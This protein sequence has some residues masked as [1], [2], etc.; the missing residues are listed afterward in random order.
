MSE[1]KT[2][3]N[4]KKADKPL[5]K[6]DVLELKKSLLSVRKD[7]E[8]KRNELKGRVSY[9]RK[10]SDSQEI[11]EWVQDVQKLYTQKDYSYWKLIRTLNKHK[12]L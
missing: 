3:D 8:K 2:R 11:P 9:M 5:S 7:L 1:M 6:K 4:Q 10:L 12:M